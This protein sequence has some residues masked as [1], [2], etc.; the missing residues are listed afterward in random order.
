MADDTDRRIA[1]LINSYIN[2]ARTQFKIE[3]AELIEYAFML[4]QKER[5]AQC[6]S[7]EVSSCAE[8]YLTA[9]HMA[10]YLTGPG[11]KVISLGYDM[12]K[13]QIGPKAV[14][15]LGLGNSC[16]ASALSARQTMWKMLGCSDGNADMMN[17]QRYIQPV[18]AENAELK[19]LGGLNY[20]GL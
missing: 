3:G 20:P 5:Q 19:A 12:L 4:S 15:K 1:D 8:H 18:S 14:Q 16:P 11:M 2:K 17:K 9:R 7:D 10:S 6:L 13:F